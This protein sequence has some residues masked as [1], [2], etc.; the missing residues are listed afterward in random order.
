MIPQEVIEEL[1]YRSPIEEVISSYVT[2]KRAGA[3]YNGLCPFHS[4]KT[5]SFTVFPKTSSFYCFGCG[6]G[7]DVVSF[8]MRAENLEYRQALDFLAKRAGISLPEDG[9]D[10]ERTISRN[11]LYEMNVCAAKFFR[12]TLYD[13]V[14]G[15]EARKYLVGRGL[16]QAIIK[17]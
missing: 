3:N 14:R 11:R 10:C 9:R 2:L 13:E 8:I 4:E 5:P 12:D 1:K 7:G 6:A 16:S 17:I 15:A